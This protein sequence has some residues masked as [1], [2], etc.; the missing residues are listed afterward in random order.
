MK[1]LHPNIYLCY[2]KK[3]LKPFGRITRG[4]LRE[5]AN[6]AL[7]EN[8]SLHKVPV[9][10]LKRNRCN[11]IISHEYNYSSYSKIDFRN[12]EHYSFYVLRIVYCA[13]L[14]S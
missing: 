7:N 14:D 12:F 5:A 6:H 9:L 8:T 13:T 1:Y 4:P 10:M 11:M 2:Q 3:G